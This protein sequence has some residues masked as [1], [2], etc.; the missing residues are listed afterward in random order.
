LEFEFWFLRCAIS[1]LTELFLYGVLGGEMTRIHYV[2]VAS[3]S[4]VFEPLFLLSLQRL[5]NK[6]YQSP[7]STWS[8]SV[9]GLLWE[10]ELTLMEEIVV[11]FR[12]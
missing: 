12:V 2:Y 10:D 3:R 5:P 11:G 8:E 9:N 7:D 6:W 1:L 4:L